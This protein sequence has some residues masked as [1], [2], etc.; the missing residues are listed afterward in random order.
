MAG[1]T[2]QPLRLKESDVAPLFL[3]ALPPKW[4]VLSPLRPLLEPYRSGA[5]SSDARKLVEDARLP[6]AA[7]LLSRPTHCLSG[8]GAVAWFALCVNRQIEEEAVAVVFAESGGECEIHLLASAAAFVDLWIEKYATKEEAPQPNLLPPPLTLD[9]A[10]G[11]LHVIDLIRARHYATMLAG[12]P[13]GSP[14]M[15]R[16]SL[17]E[18]LILARAGRDVRWL[19]GALAEFVPGFQ[20]PVVAA[21][22][23]DV[24]VD[25]DFLS[26]NPVS[27]L[28]FGE[29]GLEAAGDFLGAGLNAYGMR[30]ASLTSAGLKA[31]GSAFVA[32][33]ALTNHLFL[34]DDS[35][36][37]IH[38]P[39]GPARLRAKLQSLVDALLTQD[40]VAEPLI[41]FDSSASVATPP[42]PAPWP[43]FA[44]PWEDLAP[45]AFPAPKPEPKPV[46]VPEP[47][48]GV[49]QPISEPKP[50]V[51][52]EP[53]AGVPQPAPAPKPV[54][55]VVAP[56]PK[57]VPAVPVTPPAAF[58]PKP[59]AP[60]KPKFCRSCGKTLREGAAFCGS[61]GTRL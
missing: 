47:K 6:V 57:P 25:M 22:V 54:V 33:T 59:A 18:S 48:A 21:A 58:A 61:C 55:P 11:A 3:T 17:L 19:T 56:Q 26:S 7:M 8:R 39:V 32:A 51:V 40:G 45:S 12:K 4:N 43:P 13:F 27:G 44:A 2:P 20:C 37:V 53:E 46:V 29:T 28:G 1:D 34:F 49:P 14:L 10:F 52:P 15:S 35:T 24:L 30:A 38:Q 9:G 5:P 41:Q 31:H 23:L 50:V 60:P 16:Q 42:E 36:S